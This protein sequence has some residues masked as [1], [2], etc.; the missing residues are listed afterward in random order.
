M[1]NGTI[2][3]YKLQHIDN[4][5]FD[6]VQRLVRTFINDLPQPM[7][8][9]IYEDLNRGVDQL[10]T[11]P[12]MLV[13]LYS[14][15][16]MHQAKLNR[17]FE[18]LPDAFLQQPVIRIVDYGCGQAI[19]TM[20][21]A[22]YLAE[23][24]LSQTIKSVTLIEP[25][26]ICLKRATLHVSQFFP[27]AKIH[28]IC[29]TFDNL[30]ADD[31]ATSANIP[32]LHILSNVL[33]IQEFD[34][35]EFADKIGYDLC[36]YNQFVCVGPYFWE[37]TKD[38]RMVRF[39]WWL[40]D[41]NPNECI[42]NRHQLHPDKD[43]TYHSCVFSVVKGT[44]EKF[45]TNVTDEDIANGITDKF[46]V[47]Y[48]S[49]GK[50]LL[51]CLNDNITNY[52]IKKGTLIICDNAFN[53]CKPV[54]QRIKMYVYEIGDIEF[55]G[56][57][58]LA[59]IIIPNSIIKIGSHAFAGCNKLSSVK[60]PNSVISIGDYAFAGCTELRSLF[61]P[62]SVKSIG[63]FAFC[64]CIKLTSVI[65]SKSVKE[66]GMKLFQEDSRLIIRCEAKRKPKSWI[67]DWEPYRCSVIWGISIVDDFIYKIVDD[68]GQKVSLSYY[69]GYCQSLK[70]PKTTTIR[71]VEYTIVSID[72]YAFYDNTDL[73]SVDISNSVTS[74]GNYAFSKCCNLE[75]IIIS[76]SVKKIGDDAF[77]YCS[78][79]KTITIPISVAYIGNN[80]FGGCDKLTIKCKTELKLP[81]WDG[82]WNGYDKRPVLWGYNGFLFRIT[83]KYKQEVS[84]SKYQESEVE[85]VIP[86]ST[87]IDGVKYSVTNIDNNAFCCKTVKSITIPDTIPCN[88]SLFCHC[89]NLI[90]I[91]RKNVVS[92]KNRQ[93]T[94]V[95]NY[96]SDNGV[97]FNKDKT[98][99]ICYPVGKKGSYN[100]PDTVKEIGQG[101]FCLCKGLT[102]VN[103]PNSVIDID[104]SAFDGC[105]SLTSVVIP[106]S[107]N[108][109]GDSAFCDCKNLSSI[110]IPDS[111]N[112]IGNQ[113]FQ[114]CE[115]L[116]SVTIGYS[117]KTIG[118]YAFSNC[119]KL[120]TIIIPNSVKSIGHNAF[121]KCQNLAKISIPQSVMSIDWGTFKDCD[122]LQY[123]QYDNA[124]YLGNEE[125]PFLCLVKATS[126]E[127]TMC[128]I[129]HKCKIICYGAF[130]QCIN[131]KSILL[132]DGIRVIGSNAFCH[133]DKLVKITI[134]PS[135]KT[136]HSYAFSDCVSLK[137]V[138]ICDSV[139]RIFSDA[140]KRCKNLKTV[141]I[142]KSV[143]F[144]YD[145][146]DRDCK[147]KNESNIIAYWLRL[148]FKKS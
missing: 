14:F 144:D 45:E 72:D 92:I 22:D 57:K 37:K 3:A 113:A 95:S 146:F 61:I 130:C 69:K 11:E 63:F 4:P 2:Y 134:P 33:D 5:T 40:N 143:C 98:R 117:V 51:R 16:N 81:G 147:I 90:S 127:I 23:H 8:D 123:T 108:K 138:D 71:G 58:K 102:S 118:Y 120:S 39:A 41:Q 101:A 32:T 74:I 106:N 142:P 119:N 10:T 132:P 29:K 20:C 124:Y 50:R 28:T 109:I 135:V 38:D 43:W 85:I 21:Y 122:K 140:F 46:G 65:L 79:L 105:E 125:N 54:Y 24:G 111:V 137:S 15:G 115:G 31:L 25:S 136:I 78:S 91:N 49:D 26:E 62:N 18:Q 93:L 77:G 83:D 80:A 112:I 86:D 133:C 36:G 17:A 141:F 75:S 64:Y 96:T 67:W 89:D 97:L 27:D 70:I 44:Y 99:L 9:E 126:R 12:Q 94:I 139:D 47:V 84:I 19:G 148:L 13:Y 104:N 30:D 73:V 59:S 114:N 107:V 35:E 121:N 103:I 87:Y 48:S 66:L 60:F 128:E 68:Y 100:I 110:I 116:L 129:N 6:N 34:L 145:A 55:N 56:C 7:V 131:L 82:T 53:S 52:D 1:E 42:L 88:G 76:N